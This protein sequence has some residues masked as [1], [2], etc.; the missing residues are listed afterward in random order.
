MSD[1]PDEFVL[2]RF[3]AWSIPAVAL[4]TLAV[5]VALGAAGHLGAGVGLAA[6]TAPMLWML[7]GA[8]VLTHDRDLGGLRVSP[9]GFSPGVTP[10]TMPLDRLRDARGEPV[11][12]SESLAL[13]VEVAG[14]P[15]RLCVG[16]PERVLEAARWM[17][18]L[19]PRAGRKSSAAASD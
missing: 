10:R 12:D 11:E 2:R 3:P 18:G 9:R 13:M 17:R 1:A 15:V 6:I 7:T 8:T 5:A 4:P 16:E 14:V 19:Y